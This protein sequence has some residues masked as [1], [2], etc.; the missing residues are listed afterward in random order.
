MSDTVTEGI[1]IVVKPAFWP[2]RSSPE[3][4]QWAF[5]YSIVI[6]NQGPVAATLRERHWLITDASGREEEVRGPGVVG[7][8][9]ELGPGDTFEYTSWVRLHTPFGM[10][11]GSYRMVRPDGSSF[12]AAIGEFSLSQP[13]ALH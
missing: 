8:Q 2:E 7:R 1:R 13:H 10:M 4:R 6:T 9:P 5:T 11:R 3:H 12:E